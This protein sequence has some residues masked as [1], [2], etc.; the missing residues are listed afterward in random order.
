MNP[1]NIFKKDPKELENK[2]DLLMALE[3]LEH[4]VGDLENQ[5][6]EERD[7]NIVTRDQVKDVVTSQ[8]RLAGKEK[9]LEN[10]LESEVSNIKLNF[11]NMAQAATKLAQYK[12]QDQALNHIKS[13]NT[14]ANGMVT[15]YSYPYGKTPDTLHHHNDHLH[16]C[17]TLCP[18]YEHPYVHQPTMLSSVSINSLRPPRTIIGTC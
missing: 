10:K 17:S 1:F 8:V 9:I 11:N 5:L 3:A 14:V 7:R 13:M 16:V 2:L 6:K 15:E 18:H 4:R 12:F